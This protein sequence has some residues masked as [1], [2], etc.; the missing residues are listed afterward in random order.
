LLSGVIF[1]RTLKGG[2]Y[3]GERP[4]KTKKP[5]CK[6]TRSGE[7]ENRQTRKRKPKF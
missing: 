3:K 4:K 1:A 2:F 7:E 6:K 5:T